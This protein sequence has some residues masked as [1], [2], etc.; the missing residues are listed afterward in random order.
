MLNKWEQSIV[1]RLRYAMQHNQPVTLGA[2][3]AHIP[4]NAIEGH[5]ALQAEAERLRGENKAYKADVEAGRLVRLPYLPG[6]Q[7][8]Q[9]VYYAPVPGFCEE[10]YRTIGPKTARESDVLWLARN[11]F[12]FKTEAEARAALERAGK[13]GRDG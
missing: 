11:D 9:N 5:A 12:V 13:D 4:M 3:E 2:D 8:Y 6:D 1:D 7:Y 10:Y